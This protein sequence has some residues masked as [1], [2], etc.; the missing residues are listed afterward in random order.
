M[1]YDLHLFFVPL[2][3]SFDDA[4][5]EL[6][7]GKLPILN[8]SSDIQLKQNWSIFK[9]LLSKDPEL[10]VFPQEVVQLLTQSENE[11]DTTLTRFPSSLE[12]SSDDKITIAIYLDQV[13]VT[14]PYWYSDVDARR[15]FAKMGNY[16]RIIQECSNYAICDP[17]LNK[18]IDPEDDFEAMI[19]AYLSI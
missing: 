5:D 15:V 17:Q 11:L 19:T 18:I 10:R 7:E 9:T 13:T 14:V 12:L 6:D 1:S 2:G 8:L 4:Y 16:L 3:Y